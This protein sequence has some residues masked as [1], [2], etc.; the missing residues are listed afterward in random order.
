MS[1]F[2]HLNS[3]RNNGFGSIHFILLN[4]FDKIKIDKINGVKCLEDGFAS[5]TPHHAEL[6]AWDKEAPNQTACYW[7]FISLLLLLRYA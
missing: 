4:V 7:L 3:L 2:M 1:I 6:Y 5:T